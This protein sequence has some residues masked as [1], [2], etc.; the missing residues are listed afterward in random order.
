MSDAIAPEGAV[1]SKLEADQPQVTEAQPLA[2]GAE[3]SVAKDDTLLNNVADKTTEASTTSEDI[4][5]KKRLRIK[6]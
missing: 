3:T 5:W 6:K 2:D 4:D 1:E